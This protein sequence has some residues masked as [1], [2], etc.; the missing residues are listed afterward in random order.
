MAKV[1]KYKL[2]KRENTTMDLMWKAEDYVNWYK[3]VADPS[4]DGYQDISKVNVAGYDDYKA[5]ALQKF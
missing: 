2:T 4:Y 3:A 1:Y 5:E